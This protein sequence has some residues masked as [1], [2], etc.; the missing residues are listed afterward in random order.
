LLLG[1]DEKGRGASERKGADAGLS[2]VVAV[3]AGRASV[4]VAEPG[5]EV[6]G[7]FI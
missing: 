6:W 7:V 2:R 5:K 1:E 3:D 4:L